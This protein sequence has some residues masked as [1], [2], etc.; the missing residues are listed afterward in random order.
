MSSPKEE[1]PPASDHQSILVSLTTR[2]VWKGTVCERAHLFRI[3]YYGSFDRPLGRFLRD[4]LFDQVC[5]S[6]FEF[7]FM[8]YACNLEQNKVS[9]MFL[10]ELPVPLLRNAIRSTYPLLYP[11]TRQPYNFCKETAGNSLARRARRQNL[12]VAQ[13]PAMSPNQRISSCHEESSNV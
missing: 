7:V 8:C 2:C 9:V 6:F 10:S 4:H 11:F 3:K 5:L 13:V 1:Y 12:D